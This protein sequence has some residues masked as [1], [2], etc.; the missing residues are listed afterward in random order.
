M[1]NNRPV[2][3]DLFNLLRS[4]YRNVA[5]KHDQEFKETIAI[6]LEEILG[7]KEDKLSPTEIIEFKKEGHDWYKH[8]PSWWKDKKF[9]INQKRAHFERI[10]GHWLKM[11]LKIL[12]QVVC[13]R[14][15]LRFEFQ[16]T[17]NSSTNS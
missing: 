15:L 17:I 5:I 11:P 14:Y 1:A 6:C 12:D 16:I 3:L 7:I 13:N 8:V 4:K 9:K 10:K 2:R